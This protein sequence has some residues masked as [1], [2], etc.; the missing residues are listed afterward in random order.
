M[1]GIFLVNEELS[2]TPESSKSQAS[3]IPLEILNLWMP[4]FPLTSRES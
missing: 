2:G 3:L 4:G 1:I